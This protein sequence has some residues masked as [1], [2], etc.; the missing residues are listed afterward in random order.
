MLEFRLVPFSEVETNEAFGA[1]VEE[2]IEECGNENIGQPVVQIERYRELE[3]QGSLRCI[4]VFD[5]TTLA[6]LS[7]LYVTQ[8][9]HYPF[10]LVGIDS[11]YLRKPWRRGRTGLDLLGAMKAVAKREGAPG[12][13]VMAPVGSQLERLCTLLGLA[14]THSAFWCPA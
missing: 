1:Y 2:Y 13:P 5:G 10:P 14:K 6:G 4:G 12:L 8:S 9:Q 7:V 3:A 11:I